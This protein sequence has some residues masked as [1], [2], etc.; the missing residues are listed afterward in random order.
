MSHYN[1][2]RGGGVR[3]EGGTEVRRQQRRR[4]Q[5]EGGGGG[6]GG[7]TVRNPRNN[8]LLVLNYPLGNKSPLIVW[9]CGPA[10]ALVPLIYTPRD[11]DTVQNY[12]NFYNV[13]AT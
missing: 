8:H 5:G 2:R 3:A 11:S 7:D 13:T 6:G 1:I 12:T 4:W 9:S 10:R